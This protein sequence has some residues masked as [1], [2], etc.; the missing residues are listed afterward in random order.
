MPDRRARALIL[1]L[2]AGLALILAAAA[3]TV[4]ISQAAESRRALA[5]EVRRHCM[6]DAI[7]KNKQRALDLALLHADRH[8]VTVL[9]GELPASVD[10]VLVRALLVFYRQ[11]GAA[12]VADLPAYQN[13]ASC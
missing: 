10:P 9:A 1:Y 12:R 8:A 4:A 7:A 13:P 5:A 6:D 11:A 2:A 3:F